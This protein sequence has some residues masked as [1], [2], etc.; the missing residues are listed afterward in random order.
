M[1]HR[2]P[3]DKENRDKNFTIK[4]KEET[5]KKQMSKRI[6]D[7]RDNLKNRLLGKSFDSPAES[8]KELTLKQLSVEESD[9]KENQIRKRSTF[10]EEGSQAKKRI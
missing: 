6:S 4:K 7:L 1:H 5:K 9:K 3:L 8:E 10:G 2:V